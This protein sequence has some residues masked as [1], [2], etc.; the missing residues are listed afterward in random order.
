MP[1]ADLLV[2]LVVIWVSAQIFGELAERLG[3]PAV[4]GELIAGVVVGVGGL[5]LV[6]PH[7][8]V[9]H[10]LAEIGILILLFEI[11]LEMELRALV[12]VGGASTAVA[13]TGV[14]LPFAGGYCMGILFGADRLLAAFLGATFT[15]TSIGVTARVLR[16]LGR[17]ETTEA[18]VILGAAVIDDVFGLLI[19]TLI[20]GLLA[21]GTLSAGLAVQ[22]LAVAVAFLGGSLAVGRLVLPRLM[23]VVSGMRVRG[24][25]VLAAICLAFSFALLADLA[26]SAAIIGAFAAGLVLGGVAQRGEI[27]HGVRPVAH[28]FVP[29][30]FVTVGA[31]LD[32]AAFNP[33][34]RST[35]P[36]IG[37]MLGLSALAV[38]SK[39]VAGY[40]PFWL[41][42]RKAVVGAGM[43]PRGEV[44]LI[45]AQVGRTS[46]L[47]SDD[48]FSVVI[49][50]V[51]ITTF[52]TP[53]I[54][55][56]LFR[57]EPGVGAA[58]PSEH[59][60]GVEEIVTGM[61]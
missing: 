49:L 1:L 3:Q 45:F 2:A 61:E 47:L 14:V 11:G 54:L 20:T 26:G 24:A 23:R 10:L 58:L 41:R 52:V 40:S 37:E 34:D 35:W 28:L 51:M 57:G 42:I 46:G 25:I 55:R 16:D 18:R 7:N 17:L 44:G 4:L 39:W 48:Q 60:R 21:G 19:L 27:E 31:Q 29:I 38:A 15:A 12:R 33:L 30:F 13:V 22:M 8:E 56:W 36:L 50:V 59:P 43:V 5:G 6:D 32:V 53:V 9:I